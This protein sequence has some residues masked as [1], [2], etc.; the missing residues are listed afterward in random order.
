MKKIAVMV[1]LTVLLMLTS[2]NTLA[3]ATETTTSIPNTVVLSQDIINAAVAECQNKTT[4]GV[5]LPA[6]K[7]N[8]LAGID[9]V[10]AI[11]L[12]NGSDISRLVAVT[13]TPQFLTNTDSDTGIVYD[14][15]PIG[16]E[17]WLTP[18][19]SLVRMN[20][21][22]TKVV[23]VSLNVPEGTKLP[24]KWAV[25]ITANGLPIIPYTQQ[26]IV[27]TETNDSSV[28]FHLDYKLLQG[29]QSV[30]TVVSGLLG[31]VPT[32]SNYIADTGMLTLSGLES[33]ANREIDITYEPYPTQ[34]TAWNQIWYVTMLN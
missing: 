33:N 15:S 9:L 8:Y 16:I 12:H 27:T 7:V 34:S 6:V 1:T 24:D 4:W 18:E 20:K 23:H 14:A 25:D 29:P 3:Q 11:V 32:V 31:E 2:C 30:L 13:C 26:M 19:T 21:M 10:A 17:Q 5:D 28:T 22:D